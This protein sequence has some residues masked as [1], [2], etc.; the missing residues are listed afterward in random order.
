M[1]YR[2]RLKTAALLLEMAR[3][4]AGFMARGWSGSKFVGKKE[5]EQFIDGPKL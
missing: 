4:C 5:I 1:I 2:P 3:G